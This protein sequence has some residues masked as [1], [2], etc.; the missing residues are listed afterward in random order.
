VNELDKGLV[1]GGSDHRR[2]AY[3]LGW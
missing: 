1:K 3:V 2:G